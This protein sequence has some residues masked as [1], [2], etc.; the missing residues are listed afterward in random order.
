MQKDTEILTNST[1][2]I[3]GGAGFIGSNLL[4]KLL[5]LGVKKVKVLDDLSTGYYDNIEEFVPNPNF[6]FIEGSITDFDSCLL[7][8]KNVDIIFH[9][10]ALGSVPRSIDNPIATNNVNING[11]LNVLWA[12]KENGVKKVVYSSSSSVYG[13]NK[14]SPKIENEIGKPLSPYAVSKRANELYAQT[15]ADLYDISITGLRY[16]NVFGPKQNVNG[17]YAAVIPIFISNLLKKEPCFINGDGEISRDFTFVDNVLNANIKAA[18]AEIGQNHDIFNIALGEQTSLNE[19]YKHLES[20]IE[21]GLAPVHRTK[22][23]GDIENS[24]ANISKAI[25]ILGYMPS[26]A[27]KEDLRK[28]VAWYKKKLQEN[29][30]QQ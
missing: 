10:A 28:T 8:T 9:M 18:F 21:S 19:L 7:A 14:T 13:D 2:L 25:E 16:F 3:T 26:K 29:S 4:E 12:A 30:L 20:E 15:F 22:R 23:V 11:F 1:F 5:K 6:E 24:K 17:A 27:I